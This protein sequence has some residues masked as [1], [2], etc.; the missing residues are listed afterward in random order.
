MFRAAIVRLASA[1][2]ILKDRGAGLCATLKPFHAPFEP[3]KTVF[4]PFN[5]LFRLFKTVLKAFNTMFKACE[6]IFKPFDTVF[7][8]FKIVL[9]P[10]NTVFKLFETMFEPFKIVFKGFN[11]LFKA[12]NIVLKALKRSLK[13]AHRRPE[14]PDTRFETP[15]AR[16]TP[17]PAAY[18][19]SHARYASMTALAPASPGWLLPCSM[20]RM[21]VYPFARR[22]PKTL[23]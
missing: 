1:R 10:F 16:R 2:V 23:P 5:A 9:K 19:A 8:A 14:R 13:P 12:S 7:K 3:F 15:Q 11:T 18:P 6:T 4:E 22:C 21:P 20:P 17:G